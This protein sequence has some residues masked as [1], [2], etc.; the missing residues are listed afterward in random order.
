MLQST[1]FNG[2][3]LTKFASIS[4]DGALAMIGKSKLALC[5]K[6]HIMNIGRIA[7][8]TKV[9][10]NLIRSIVCEDKTL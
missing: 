9:H 3:N 5:L 6:N 8:L 1:A 10:C 4:T 7:Y 2:I